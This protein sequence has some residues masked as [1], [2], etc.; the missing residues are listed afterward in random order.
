M[1][2]VQNFYNTGCLGFEVNESFITLI[3]KKK[4][5]TSIGDYRLINLVGSIYKLIAKLLVNRLRKV[6]GEVVEAH[7]FAFIS[8][9]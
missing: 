7:Q 9:R 6:I 3:P 4:N 8:G 1:E 5:P 2:F